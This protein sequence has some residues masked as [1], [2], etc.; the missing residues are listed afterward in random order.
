MKQVQT[1]DKHMLLCLPFFISLKGI[2]WQSADGVTPIFGST[3]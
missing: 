2:S 3:C 1:S